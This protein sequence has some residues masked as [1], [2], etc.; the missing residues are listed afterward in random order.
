MVETAFISNPDEEL[1]LRSEQHQAQFAESILRGIKRY[2][3]QNPPLSRTK[4][5]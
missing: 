3:A 1:K 5:S 2:F 4:A